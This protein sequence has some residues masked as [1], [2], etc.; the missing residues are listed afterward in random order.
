MGWQTDNAKNGGSQ[1]ALG[2]EAATKGDKRSCH[3]HGNGSD[4]DRS[5]LCARSN[6]YEQ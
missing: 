2:A 6:A 1:I 5:E 3:I 4:M